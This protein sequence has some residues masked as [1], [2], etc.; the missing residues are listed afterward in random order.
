MHPTLLQIGELKFHAYPTFLAI[1]FLLG[2]ILAVRDGQ[3]LD[4]PIYG[5]TQGGLWV[6]LGALIGAK[7]FWILQYSEP[8]YLYHAFFLWESGL[9][10]YG[11]LIGGAVALVAYLYYTKLPLLRSADVCAPYL[12][13]G[14][15]IVRIGCFLNGCCWG[16]VAH[17]PWAVQ[18]PKYSYAFKRQ[19]EDG[20]IDTSAETALPVHPTQLYMTFGLLMAFVAMK[21]V[22]PRR[23]FDGAIA[24][25]YCFCYG[26]VRFTVEAFRGDSAYSVGGLTVSQTISVCL[27]IF[28]LVVL[29]IKV[30]RRPKVTLGTGINE[31][32]EQ[33]TTMVDK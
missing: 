25:M 32:N 4:P 27:F 22:F 6:F 16:A 33:T 8:K 21:W 17:V 12:A 19:L 10:F 31:E 11:G 3:R 2:T 14:E 26:V 5:S 1:A 30:V 28:A 29:I 15:A 9:V 24:V 7:A 13:L 20:L 23:R 18:F